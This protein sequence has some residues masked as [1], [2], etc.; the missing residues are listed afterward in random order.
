MKLNQLKVSLGGDA[1][2]LIQNYTH[3]SQLLEPL[4]TL[5]NAYSKPEFIVSELYKALKGM[6]TITTFWAIRSAKEQ[7]AT[8]KVALATVKPLCLK[9]C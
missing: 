6:A 9:I 3:G 4:Q 2:E 7:V 5:E 1:L 8:L